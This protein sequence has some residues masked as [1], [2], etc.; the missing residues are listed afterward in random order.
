MPVEGITAVPI[1]NA[2]GHIKALYIVPAPPAR[3]RYIPIEH[4]IYSL[5]LLLLLFSY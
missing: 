5:L 4:D 1:R 3:F 2:F